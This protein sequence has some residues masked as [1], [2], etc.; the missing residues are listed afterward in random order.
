MSKKH[1]WTYNGMAVCKIFWAYAHAA[2]HCTVERFQA[3][4]K[5]GRLFLDV[6]PMPRASGVYPP[7][8]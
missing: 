6:A 8:G 5:D 3:M 4:V 1:Q 7:G 2:S